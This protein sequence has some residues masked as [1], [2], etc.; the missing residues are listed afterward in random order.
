MQINLTEWY[1]SLS[2]QSEFIGMIVIEQLKKYVTRGPNLP[3]V[4]A[5]TDR[6]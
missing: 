4:D 5:M 1:T 3:Y 2:H 6:L